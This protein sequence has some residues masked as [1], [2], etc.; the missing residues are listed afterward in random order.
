MITLKEIR[1]LLDANWK[2]GNVSVPVMINGIPVTIVSQKP[3]FYCIFKT[4]TSIKFGYTYYRTFKNPVIEFTQFN[5]LKS[6]LEERTIVKEMQL[7]PD[8]IPEELKDYVDRREV[9]DVQLFTNRNGYRDI[10]INFITS[11]Y[12]PYRQLCR[13]VPELSKTNPQL[14]DKIVR[15]AIYNQSMFDSYLYFISILTPY[16]SQ[17]SNLNNVVICSSAV[18]GV[19]PIREIAACSVFDLNAADNRVVELEDGSVEPVVVPITTEYVG[20]GFTD[21]KYDRQCELKDF[22]FKFNVA[23]LILL[24]ED[25]GDGKISGLARFP[26]LNCPML[27]ILMVNNKIYESLIVQNSQLIYERKFSVDKIKGDILM[28]RPD[29]EGTLTFR[30]M[31]KAW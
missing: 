21:K 14:S 11:D 17:F 1:S 4:A 12:E 31:I 25:F 3:M 23:G 30:E 13:K 27:E 8:E 9:V 2:D 10:A 16:V 26:R 28:Y 24:R 18:D 7:S 19:S 20:I 29:D 15:Y 6:L 5:N 22:R